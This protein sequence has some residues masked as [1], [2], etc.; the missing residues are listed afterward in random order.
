MKMRGWQALCC[1]LVAGVASTVLGDLPSYDHVVIVIEE[2]HSLNQVIGS[3]NAPYINSLATNG[4]SFTNMFAITHPSQ[5]NYLHFFSGASQG[6]TGDGVPGTFP[7]GAGTSNLGGALLN[8]GKTFT[9]YSETMP[10]V[11]FNGG[12]FG[13]G[14]GYMRK[15]NPWVNWQSD[16]PTGFQL[17]ATTNQPFTAFPTDYSTLPNLS[18]VVPNEANDMHDGTVAQGDTWLQNNLS[19]YATWAKANNSLLIVTF[20]ED[21]SASRNRIPTVFYGANVVTGQNTA[22]WTLHNLLRT[23]EDTYGTTH[24]GAAANVKP[25]IGS[26]AT[27]MPIVIRGFQKGAG[28]Y[29]SAKDTYIDSSAG[30]TN[31]NHGGDSEV[32]VDGSPSQQGLIRFDNIVGSGATQVSSG[33]KVLSAKLR[34]YTGNTTSDESPNTFGLY[35]MLRSWEEGDT[36]DSL[37]AG[38]SGGEVS[39]SPSFTVRPNDEGAYVVFDV[40]D[41]VQAWV[42]GTLTNFGWMIRNDT[43]NNGWRFISS[44]NLTVGNRPYLEIVVPEPTAVMALLLAIGCLTRRPRRL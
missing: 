22:T 12:S 21:E 36:Y 32:W 19:A 28:G 38:I 14:S 37:V 31:F 1:A 24:S 17:P 7:F 35:T 27:D 33:T 30:S 3:A 42:D 43:A 16:T 34:L 9:G 5:P 25:I 18:I 13:G 26:F 40:T 39:A 23:I 8:A 44:D 10:D 41:T 4:S 2:N 29:T 20:D 15:H 11:G 6:V